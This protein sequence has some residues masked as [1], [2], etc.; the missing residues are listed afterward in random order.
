MRSTAE[1]TDCRSPRCN[2][3]YDRYKIV[4]LAPYSWSSRVWAQMKEVSTRYLHSGRSFLQRIITSGKSPK[5]GYTSEHEFV[6]W[7]QTFTLHLLKV[8]QLKFSLS[9]NTRPQSNRMVF[10]FSCQ[11]N[12]SL[13]RNGSSICMFA[14]IQISEWGA[15]MARFSSFNV[16]IWYTIR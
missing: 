15:T 9:Y 11:Q 12:C 16:D 8:A 1:V 2:P 6:V 4:Q 5:Q 7:K 3:V 10:S 14:R 13:E